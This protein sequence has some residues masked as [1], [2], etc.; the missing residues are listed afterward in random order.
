MFKYYDKNGNILEAFAPG[1]SGYSGIS[2]YSGVSGDNPGS[3]GYSGV[4]G[5]SGAN[6]GA[7]G[8]SGVSG[9]SGKSGYSGISGYSG[10][11]GSGGT[12]GYSG[13]SG[14]SG[15]SG[16]SGY[17]GLLDPLGKNFFSSLSLLPANTIQEQLSTWPTFSSISASGS[18]TYLDSRALQTGSDGPG[19]GIFH[20]Y[21][22]GAEYTK[23]LIIVGLVRGS[24]TNQG[25]FVSD[26][27]STT[28]P[29]GYIFL[30]EKNSS[31]SR[32]YN[33]P[34]YATAIATNTVMYNVGAST[35]A[36]MAFYIN[37]STHRMV[38]FFRWGNE[39]WSPAFDV[40]DATNITATQARY[41]GTYAHQTGV[42]SCPMA[43]YAE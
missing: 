40:T 5:Y 32:I 24:T 21:D 12:S 2:G 4:S 13:V 26:D 42:F 35:G 6:P 23:I 10:S 27:A 3:S 8:Y 33:L 18:V 7:S 20:Y 15:Y 36:G 39:Q 34:S 17:S 41:I 1:A 29:T 43:I 31:R 14:F 37:L 19:N 28:V 25:L 38:C 9:Y 30:D 22:M 16:V 11:G